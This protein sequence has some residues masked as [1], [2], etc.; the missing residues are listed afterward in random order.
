MKLACIVAAALALVGCAHGP[1]TQGNP[2]GLTARD[3]YPLAVGNQWTYQAQL[4]GDQRTMTVEILREANGFFEDNQHARL[5]QDG[6]GLRDD[7]RYL[8]KNPLRTGA[9]WDN[10]VSVSAREHYRIAEADAPCTVPAGTFQ[11]CVTVESRTRTPEVTLVNELT[12]APQVGLV[13]LRVHADARGKE[14]PQTDY[15]LVR[16]A[17][18][19][20]AGPKVFSASH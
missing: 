6:E 11:H 17:L 7:R 20:G 1:S 19:G 14:I 2:S 8:L 9:E 12:F 15:A 3:Y 5:T 13:Q 10:V 4:L 16:Y 18:K